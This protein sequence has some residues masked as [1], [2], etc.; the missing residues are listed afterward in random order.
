MQLL[1][2]SKGRQI[3]ACSISHQHTLNVPSEIFTEF[4]FLFQHQRGFQ[5]ITEDFHYDLLSRG[6]WVFDRGPDIIFNPASLPGKLELD[7]QH[8]GFD[9]RQPPKQYISVSL[10]FR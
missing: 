9:L 10:N 2:A 5:L 1:V 8:K 6:G 4:I 7:L 3:S